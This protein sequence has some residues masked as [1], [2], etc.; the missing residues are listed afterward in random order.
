MSNNF[1]VG[2]LTNNDINYHS[3]ITIPEPEIPL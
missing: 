3:I 2:I 1:S